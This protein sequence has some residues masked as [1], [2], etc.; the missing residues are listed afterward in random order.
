MTLQLVPCS[1][2]TLIEEVFALERRLEKHRHFP[3]AQMVRLHGSAPL[4]ILFNYTHFHVYERAGAP[5]QALPPTLG[6][7]EN[8]LSIAVDFQ[9]AARWNAQRRPHQPRALPNEALEA[10]A[11]IYER[12]LERLAAQPQADHGLM[13][14]LSAEQ[15]AQ[16][17]V[18]WNA[19]EQAYERDRGIAELF[20][21][22]VERTPQATAV[23]YE[24]ERLSYR[25]LEER[26]NQLAHHLRAQGV[27]PE[28]VVGL[29]AERGVQM[30][31]GLL[32]ILKAGG[33]YLPLDPAYPPARL[34]YMIE[35]AGV[36]W[37][38]T[39]EAAC[40]SSRDALLRR[41]AWT[42]P[43]PSCSRCRAALPLSTPARATPPTSSIPPVRAGA[44]RGDERTRRARQSPDVRRRAVPSA[45]VTAHRRAEALPPHRSTLSM[46]ELVR[47]LLSGGALAASLP[48]AGHTDPQA[49]RAL[50]VRAS[51]APT[52]LSRPRSLLASREEPPSA[53]CTCHVG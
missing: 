23:V 29:C 46:C 12:V 45:Q 52:V 24:E 33:A 48:T 18:G 32:G 47:P 11:Q 35:N 20:E 31:I 5:T 51:G 15:H 49:L 25:Q 19:T 42:P 14:A 39:H 16:I 26:A 6:I 40:A 38:L 22:Q 41:C 4:E 44:Q 36:Q 37:V 50:I 28:T 53:P 17:V 10:L 21:G 3:F 13:S 30:V 34:A 43:P 27:G 9:S 2:R 8:D 7:A 1:W